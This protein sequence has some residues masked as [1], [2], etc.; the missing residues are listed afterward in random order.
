M[1]ET[2]ITAAFTVDM[3]LKTASTNEQFSAF[4]NRIENLMEGWRENFRVAAEE[5]GLTPSWSN[6]SLDYLSED[7]FDGNE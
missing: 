7:E 1:K 2:V 6:V 3:S 5:A 4:S